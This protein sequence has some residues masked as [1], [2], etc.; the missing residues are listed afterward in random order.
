[1]D[2]I[3]KQEIDLCALVWIKASEFEQ[4]YR[5]CA[6]NLV[7]PY[8]LQHHL[9]QNRDEFV[10]TMV[11]KDGFFIFMGFRVHWTM[12]DHIDSIQVFQTKQ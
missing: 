2:T 5:T 7:L 8:F 11:L 1:M 6:N 3:T 4:K 9:V 10:N 12:I